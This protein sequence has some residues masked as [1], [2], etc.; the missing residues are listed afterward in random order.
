MMA[1]GMGKLPTGTPL[2]IPPAPL[3]DAPGSSPTN[4]LQPSKINGSGVTP[5]AIAETSQ[6][7]A[8]KILIAS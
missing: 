4:P 3:R 8:E 5:G 7:E 1:T 6:A 2:G